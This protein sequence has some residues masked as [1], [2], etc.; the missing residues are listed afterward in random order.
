M[1]W[2]E[3]L[4]SLPDHLELWLM[5][6]CIGVILVGAYALEIVAR[7]HFDRAQR[8]GHAGF[9]Y[10]ADED[11]FHCHQGARL[12]LH[13]FDDHRQLAVYRAPANR[14]AECP[15]KAEC[16]PEQDA[17]Q[18]YRS[19]A[20]WAETDVGRFHVYLGLVM[21]AAAC[22]LASVALTQWGGQR[23]TGCLVVALLL[24]THLL[25]IG[26]LSGWARLRSISD[27][28]DEAN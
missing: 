5:L 23:G 15:H 21:F 3:A 26:S 22:V 25:I 19:L 14:C 13:L 24:S 4:C 2:H 8:L 6:G 27:A 7:V 16:T 9:R 12:S 10:N 20:S 1:P 18:V 28:L 11:H 17:R